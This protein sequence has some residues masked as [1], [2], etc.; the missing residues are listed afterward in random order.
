[1]IYR[2]KRPHSRARTV[3]FAVVMALATVA[4]LPARGSAETDATVT[5]VG[6]GEVSAEPDQANITVGVQLYHESA[7]Q[8]S[9]EI[10]GRMDAVIEA[11]LAIGIAEREIQTMNYS[12][13]FE[14]DY[15]APQVSRDPSGTPPGVYRVENMVRIMIGDV[16]RAAEVVEAAISAGANQMYGIQFSFSDPAAL[17][18]RA[19]SIAM[20]DA[21]TRAEELAAEG[22]RSLGPVLEISEQISTQPEFAQTRLMADGYG[23]G[24]VQPGTSRYSAAVRVTYRLR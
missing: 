3:A 15:Q 1:M 13:H 2:L 16:T 10:R 11:L 8:A 18:S 21:R 17:D 4:V 14:R 19:R 24:P 12:I 6:R 7:Q 9:A 20:S 5:V 22:G 23:G